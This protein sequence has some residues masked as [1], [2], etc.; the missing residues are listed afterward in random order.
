LSTGFEIAQQY[1]DYQFVPITRIS[2]YLVTIARRPRRLARRPRF[3]VSH[4]V[5]QSGQSR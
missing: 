5:A 3:G 4:P 1:G 2:P